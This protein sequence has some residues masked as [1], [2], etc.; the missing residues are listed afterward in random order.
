MAKYYVTEQISENI[1][2]TPEGF[3]LCIGVPVTRTGY[4]EYGDGETPLDS[5]DDGIVRI[6]RKA[7]DV[8][9]PATMASFEGKSV[10]ITHPEDWVDP[11]NWKELT[12]G[13]TMNVR[14]G[15]GKDN[16]LLLADLLI[17]DHKAILLV[18]NGLRE[19]SCGYEAEFTQTGDG[20]GRQTNIVGNHV[21]L[22]KEGRAG[23]N[24]AIK[25]NHKGVYIMSKLSK[26]RDGLIK[27]VT[28]VID[29][30]LA[31]QKQKIKD[32]AAKKIK[33]AEAEAKTKLAKKIKAKD[34]KDDAEDA[35]ACDNNAIMDAI[36]KLNDRFDA[37]EGKSKDDDDMVD[38]DSDVDDE[39]EEK[40]PAADEEGDVDDDAASD[41]E[42]RINDHESRISSLEGKVGGA[43]KADD[44][45]SDEDDEEDDDNEDDDD[46]EEKDEF[47][48]DKGKG[49]VVGDAASISRAE[50]LA[51]GINKKSKTLKIDALKTAA[52]SK[53]GKRAIDS[54]TGGKA[55]NFKDAKTVDNIFIA[56]S[57]ILKAQRK[58]KLA[59]TKTTDTKQ[60]DKVV[61][62][63]GAK[64]VTAEQLNE[65]HAKHWAK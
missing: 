13:T 56:A 15:S 31:V 34:K 40:D 60:D 61:V 59:T 52:K 50:I 49:K 41:H 3:L 48:D 9:H 25:D 54:L 8:F 14:R 36:T 16:T 35:P 30:E 4:L 64:E 45:E 47:F 22:V 7:E 58:S 62:F 1:S 44:A 38:D 53:D 46:D 39:E 32:E 12:V 17:T 65:L 33:D 26:I 21:A 63:N 37:L 11:R 18:K 29:D 43:D 6:L 57:E 23:S 19:V 27:S 24:C 51:P 28:K 5:D 2:E 42:T 55:I 10:T 20:E